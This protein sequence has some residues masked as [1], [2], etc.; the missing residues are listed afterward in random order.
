MSWF[1]MP[2]FHESFMHFHRRLYHS[3]HSLQLGDFMFKLKSICLFFVGLVPSIALADEAAVRKLLESQAGKIERLAK[4][5]GTSLWEV[6]ADGQVFYADDTGKYLF[7]GSL[8]EGKTGKNLTNERMFSMLPLD[9][10]VKQVRG[11]GKQTLVTFEDP[12][13]GYCKKL[14]KDLINAKDVTIY[15]FLYPVL[16]QDSVEKSKAIWCAPDRAKA[17]NDFMVNGKVSPPASEKC[18]LTGLNA[19]AETGRK[20][21]IN[22]TPAIFF[23]NGDRAGGYIPLPEIE[24]RMAAALATSAN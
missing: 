12:N 10:A 18:N 21:R 5:S 7:F 9:V 8:I 22:G 13:C 16:G 6:S 23:G 2:S 17:W 4:V 3:S 11:N 15:T 20:M 19:S 1:V 24:K 14:A